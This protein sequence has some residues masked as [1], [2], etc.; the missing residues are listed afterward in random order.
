MGRGG[1][2]LTAAAL[3]LVSALAACAFINHVTPLLR[4]GCATNAH[5]RLGDNPTKRRDNTAETSSK[6]IDIPRD[7]ACA[8]APESRFDCA[9]DRLLSRRGCEERGCC[10]APLPHSAG[11]PWCFYPSRYPGYRMGP[12]TPTVRGQEA[13]LTRAAPPRLPREISPVHLEA[14]GETAGS[15][16]VMLV[17]FFVSFQ[18]RNTEITWFFRFPFENQKGETGI[19]PPYF[20]SAV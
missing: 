12:L 7:D 20:V 4:S 3:L 19:P 11:P 13:T 14:T 10:Y 8:M 1:S 17:C 5:E 18:I 6:E 2:S 9:R 15:V 16:Y